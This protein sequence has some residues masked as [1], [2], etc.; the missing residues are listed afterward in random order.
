PAIIDVQ[1]DS[2]QTAFRLGSL[3][4]RDEVVGKR[5]GGGRQMQIEFG[6]TGVTHSDPSEIVAEPNIISSFKTQDLCVEGK[7]FVEISDPDADEGDVGDHDRM[8][9]LGAVEPLLPGCAFRSRYPLMK[10]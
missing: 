4:C 9:R 5:T 6:L 10:R 3:Q 1:P 2:R 8:L 7:S